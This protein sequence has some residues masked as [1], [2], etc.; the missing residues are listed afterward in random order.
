MPRRDAP[1]RDTSLKYKHI[2]LP[3]RSIDN[4]D[5]IEPARRGGC[6]FRAAPHRRGAAALESELAGGEPSGGNKKGRLIARKLGKR[7]IFLIE[8]VRS[9][10]HGFGGQDERR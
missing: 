1:P 5:N 4:A 3:N 7:T 6:D 9:W 10:L 8:D 2:D